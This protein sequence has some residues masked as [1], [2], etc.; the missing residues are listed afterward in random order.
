MDNYYIA[1]LAFLGCLAIFDL[2]VGVSNDAVNFLN[3][4]LGCRI[5]KFRTTMWVATFGVLLGATF[6]SGM[7]EIAR[8]GVF[9]PQM[10]SFSEIMIIFFAV[11]IADVVLL[12]AFNSLGLPT[13]T[14]VSIVFELLGSAMAAAFFKL[15]MDG[16]SIEMVFDYINTSKALTIISA[17]LVSVVVAFISGAVIQYIMRLIFSFYFE[18]MYYK[19]GAIFGGFCITAIMYFLVMKGAKGASFMQ[20]EWIAWIDANTRVILIS[21]F[22]GLSIFFQLLIMVFKVNIFKIVILSGTFSLAFAFAGN[23]LVNFVG[24][25]LAAL[26]SWKIWSSS[27]VADSSFM[28][29][30]LLCPAKTDTFFLIASGLVMT[31]TLWF[32]KKAHRVIQTSLNLSAQQSDHELFGSSLAGRVIVRTTMGLGSIVNQIIPG[33]VKKGLDSRFKHR[34]LARGEE[35]LP[36]DYVRASVNLVLSAI[37]IASATSLQLPLSTT[38]V[39]FMVAMGSS[40]ADGAWDRET[41]VYRISGVLTVIS[42][43][44]LTALTAST[45]A[46]IICLLMFFGGSVVAFLLALLA[47]AL[48]IR[49]N[50]R[51]SKENKA[52]QAERKMRYDVETIRGILNERISQNL[53]TTVT[54]YNN[55]VESFLGDSESGLRKLKLKANANF[56]RLTR[57]RGLYYRM[58]YS[59]YKPNKEDFDARYSYFRTFTHLRDVGRSLQSLARVTKDHI[60]NRHRTF[61]GEL[62]QD[63]ADLSQLL[64]EIV[65][66]KQDAQ[67]VADFHKNAQTLLNRIEVIQEKLLLTGP[68]NGFSSRGCEIYLSFLLFARELINHYEIIQMLQQKLNHSAEQTQTSQ[69]ATPEA[70]PAV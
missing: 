30:G 22:V 63:L 58:N 21:L 33:A 54:L 60:A 45:L 68:E 62:G 59:K 23:D 43:W 9:H 57:E 41:A 49:S 1:V 42:G 40:F 18:R 55:I 28:M 14:T 7:M 39:T 46:A 8:S 17:I 35:P 4:A 5:A 32:S 26:D 47:C 25:P 64:V 2:F 6:S 48:L 20:P 38:Y 69:A 36:F 65:G 70:K 24:V 56:D 53:F 67:S 52:F 34:R 27:G 61:Q 44:F 13:S 12:D 37:L 51:F 3:S 15:Y 50:I 31:F 19:I 16:G 66:T 10:F 11:M 29:E